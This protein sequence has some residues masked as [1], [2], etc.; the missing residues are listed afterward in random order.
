MLTAGYA[1]VE[2]WPYGDF[3]GK[4]PFPEHRFYEQALIKQKLSSIPLQHRLRVDQR[5]VGLV[6]EPHAAVHSWQLR[7]RFRYMLR[8][9]FPL[10]LGDGKRRPFGLAIYDEVFVNFGADRGDAL[11]GSESGLCRTQ[12]RTE[13]VE[14]V[15]SRLP[16]PIHCA[17]ERP[18]NGTK[19]RTAIRVVPTTPFG[20]Q[21]VNQS[22]R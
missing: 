2:A 18:D 3:P 19:P 8:A 22:A 1:F 13:S 7:Q 12:I 21:K 10:P 14:P 17:T 11:P 15:R 5:L 20:R 9:D 16:E 6:P 4:A